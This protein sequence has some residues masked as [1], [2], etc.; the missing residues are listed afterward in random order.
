[1]TAEKQTG[2][3]TEIFSLQARVNLLEAQ[4]LRLNVPWF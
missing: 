3:K 1:M 2:F 4:T